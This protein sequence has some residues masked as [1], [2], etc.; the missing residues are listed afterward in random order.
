MGDI[1]RVMPGGRYVYVGLDVAYG[2]GVGRSDRSDV[3]SDPRTG[4]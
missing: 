4:P 3:V 2:A 1:G